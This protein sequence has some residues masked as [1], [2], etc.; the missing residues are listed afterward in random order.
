MLLDQLID[1]YSLVIIAAVI[2]SWVDVPH[3]HP[4]VKFLRNVTEPVLNPIRGA[5]PTMGGIDYSPVVVLIGLQLLGR[6]F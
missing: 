1:L 6:I 2:A 5:L 4:I 3:D